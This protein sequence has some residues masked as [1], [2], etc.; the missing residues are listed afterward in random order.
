MFCFLISLTIM[1]LGVYLFIFILCGVYWTS[2]I[3][4]FIFFINFWK[5]QLL[6]LQ[7]IILSLSLSSSSRTTIMYRLVCLMVPHKSINLCSFLFFLLSTF[8]TQQFQF[9][10]LQFTYSSSACQICY[11]APAQKMW[12]RHKLM[13][14]YSLFLYWKN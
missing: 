11:W 4:E 3:F 12:R 13:K 8:Q 9:S 10:C 5:F 14:R 6:F 7:I 1:S 2:W